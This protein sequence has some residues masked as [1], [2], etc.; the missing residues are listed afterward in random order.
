MPV[1]TQRHR[2]GH[3]FYPTPD[4]LA[5][6][7]KLYAQDDKGLDAIVHVHYFA[8]F[9]DWWI[10]EFSADFGNDGEAFG[11]VRLA[12]HP[13]GAELGYIDPVELELI[14]YRGVVVER[15]LHWTPKTIREAARICG[16]G[17]HYC[18]DA[19]AHARDIAC[20]SAA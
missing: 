8:P 11:Y 15:D 12:V 3:R 17:R 4:E 19:D 20:D 6:Y 18:D 16:G 2:R 10:T 1:E 14:N 9:G 5:T 13:D 7:P